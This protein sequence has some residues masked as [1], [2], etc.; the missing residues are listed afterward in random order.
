MPSPDPYVVLGI[1]ASVS[2]S[3]LRRTYR[4]L[5]QLYHPD[6][7]G[8]SPAEAA[9]RFAEVR[10]A[11]QRALRLRGLGG[12][13]ESASTALVATPVAATE[14]DVPDSPRRA[15]AEPWLEDRIAAFE[16]RLAATREAQT[17]AYHAA[18]AAAA[19]ASVRPVPMVER[20][21]LV[22]A[23]PRTSRLDRPRGS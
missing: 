21:D 3:E 13:A 12:P 22:S 11:Y 19:A 4:R 14:S 9:A 8:A 15:W 7:N 1:S 17:R 6:H 18:V 5:V 10:E 16:K 20:L 23:P 2:D